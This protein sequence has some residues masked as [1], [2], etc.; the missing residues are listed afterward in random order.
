MGKGVQTSVAT[1]EV[2]VENSQ[3]VRKRNDLRPVTPFLNVHLKGCI[4]YQGD[5]AVPCSYLLRSQ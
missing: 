1:V 4:S 5:N 3:T 2:S